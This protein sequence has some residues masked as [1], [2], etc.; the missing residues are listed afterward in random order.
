M[1]EGASNRGEPRRAGQPV[2]DRGTSDAAPCSRSADS[3]VTNAEVFAFPPDDLA[4]AR[5]ADGRFEDEFLRTQH[6]IRGPHHSARVG[7]IE[8]QTTHR[9]VA[10]AK[11]DKGAFSG[12]RRRGLRRRSGGAPALG[13][14]RSGS[15]LSMHR[16]SNL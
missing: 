4:V 7:G 16:I 3:Q 5:R 6:D 8:D 2:R 11:D 10:A 12:V 15:S 14:S 1:I 13:R 9:T